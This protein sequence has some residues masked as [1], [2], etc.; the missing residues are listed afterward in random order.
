MLTLQAT[1]RT[2]LGK[3][4]KRLRRE[5]NIPAVLYGRK[6]KSVPIMI[7]YKAFEKIYRDAGENTLITLGVE[8]VGKDI[9]KE[10][11]VLIRDAIRDPLTR[12]F[13]HTDFYQVPMDEKIK[14][15]VP[16]EFVNESPVVKDGTAV[17]ARNIYELEVS[18]LPKDL[19]RGITVDLSR[20]QAI[21]DAIILKDIILPSGVE[22][23][24]AEDFVI[25]AASMPEKEEII[26]EK[27]EAETAP[28]AADI[29]T[30]G[31]VKREEKAVKE[32]EE[33][34]AE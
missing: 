3:K 24:L 12:L 11:T 25:A 13:T 34:A 6:L 16:I 5:G 1:I 28:A 27:T 15:S 29:K 17:L 31:E 4:A 7:G 14:V 22:I 21:G 10:N 19:P 9:P 30:E 18:A 23:E 33:K 20:L 32:A 26:E 2:E 8:N